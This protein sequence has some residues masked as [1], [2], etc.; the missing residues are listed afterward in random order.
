ME[1]I[2]G[3]AASE[4]ASGADG[5][6]SGSKGSSLEPA[7]DALDGGTDC[8]ICMSEKRNTALMPCRLRTTEG[9]LWLPSA[10]WTTLLARFVLLQAP[11]PLQRLRKHI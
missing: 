10:C 5:G 3:L 2:Y 4:G 6:A 7:G 8:V 1:E 9:V 11:V